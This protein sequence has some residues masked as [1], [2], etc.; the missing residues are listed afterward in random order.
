M[1]STKP[2]G[3]TEHWRGCQ[4]A[5]MAALA[6]FEIDRRRYRRWCDLRLV[7]VVTDDA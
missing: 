7:A 1:T 3:A 4:R 6:V 2:G 5:G